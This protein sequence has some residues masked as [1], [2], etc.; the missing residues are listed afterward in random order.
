MKI[1]RK[2]NKQINVENNRGFNKGMSQLKKCD[3]ELVIR[4][5]CEVLE[6]SKISFFRIKNNGVGVVRANLTRQ[7]IEKIFAKYRITQVWDSKL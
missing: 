5:I 2:K 7:A 6:I 1:A 3:Q 4:E